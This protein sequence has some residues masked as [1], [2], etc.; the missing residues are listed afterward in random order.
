MGKTKK[1]YR[2][3]IEFLNKSRA[4]KH[5]W[6]KKLN[7][8][9]KSQ[10]ITQKKCVL[11]SKFRF[12]LCGGFCGTTAKRSL[13]YWARL[14]SVYFFCLVFVSF[15]RCCSSI[16]VLSIEIDIHIRALCDC[17]SACD[18]ILYYSF[19]IRIYYDLFDLVLGKMNENIT[20]TVKKREL[21]QAIKRWH[22]LF[23]SFP[24]I[25]FC[26][27]KS[28][29]LICLTILEHM[30]AIIWCNHAKRL[31]CVLVTAFE[32]N[33][34]RFII[35]IYMFELVLFY[36]YVDMCALFSF[37]FNLILSILIC[38]AQWTF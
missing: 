34:Q 16:Q 21:W 35:I 38:T 22:N 4:S 24:R 9:N 14:L 2:K 11:L 36:E 12:H 37:I 27:L 28:H 15:F 29:N 7:D 31:V 10:Y 18:W 33:H 23:V 1:K 32:T 8:Q 5:R 19:G 26:T 20:K 30:I 25:F 6:T 3:S 13:K 17:C